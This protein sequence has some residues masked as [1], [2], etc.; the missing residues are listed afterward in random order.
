MIVDWHSH[1]WEVPH[2]EPEWGPELDHNVSAT[3]SREGGYDSH[4]RAMDAAGVDVSIVLALVSCHLELDI[5]NE[6]VAGFVEANP[7]RAIG[8]ASVDPSDPQAVDKLRY[9][10]TDLGLKGL[11]LSP[12]YQAFHPHSPE[13]W[14]VY[15]AA[16]ELGLVVTFHQGGVFARRGVLEY[17]YPALLDKVARSFP[18]MKIIVAHMGQPWVHETVAVMFK[19]P[20][21]FADLSARFGRP[22]QLYT[23]LLNIL[24]Y[25]VMD[26]VLF[27]SDF[28]IFDPSECLAKFRALGTEGAAGLPPIDP[29]VIESVITD[30]P[31]SLLGLTP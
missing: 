28:P 22:W 24:D 6:Y 7:G 1:V 2:L 18:Q 21:V 23:I 8:F 16:A 20:N 5:P 25:G 27:G 15:E 19:N 14:R 4:R 30:R 9:A 26:R 17:A 3:P 13:A 10:A 12:P 29:A 11:K 31:L